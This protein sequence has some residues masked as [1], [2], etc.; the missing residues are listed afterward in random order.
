M[1]IRHSPEQNISNHL[2]PHAL[3]N[4][5]TIP[6]LDFAKYPSLVG[7]GNVGVTQ[8]ETRVRLT[9]DDCVAGT[10]G[11]GLF[12]LFLYWFMTSTIK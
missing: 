12:F 5:V 4:I 6:C 10:P 1:N 7:G 8:A 9:H 11:E 2:Q 3:K